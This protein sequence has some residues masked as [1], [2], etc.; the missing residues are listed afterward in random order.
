MGIHASP[1]VMTSFDPGLLNGLLNELL[2]DP[3]GETSHLALAMDPR[4]CQALV[5]FAG[6]I[7]ILFPPPSRRKDILNYY[8]ECLSAGKTTVLLK[9]EEDF[10]HVPY[11]EA[12]ALFCFSRFFKS[13][14][15][16]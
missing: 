13:R 8:L 4:R 10:F 5:V 2:N 6:L 16:C 12:F 9:W 14:L 11:L 1:F 15:P 3:K 7:H